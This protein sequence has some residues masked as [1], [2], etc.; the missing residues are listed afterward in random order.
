NYPADSWQHINVPQ[1]RQ[2]LTQ[3]G[4]KFWFFA[5]SARKKVIQGVM[6]QHALS[7]APD[8]AAD[9]PVI[10]LLQP[11]SQRLSAISSETATLPGWNSLETDYEKLAAT[12]A[13]AEEIRN[14]LGTLAS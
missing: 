10:D 7:S 8:L 1:I 5:T 12:L 14:K 4:K 2:A 9:L 3:A 13:L 6:Q 11:L